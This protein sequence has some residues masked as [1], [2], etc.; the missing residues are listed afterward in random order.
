M[1]SSLYFATFDLSFS[2]IAGVVFKKSIRFELDIYVRVMS[3][4]TACVVP[5]EPQGKF[6]VY[7]PDRTIENLLA[8]FLNKAPSKHVIFRRS[9]SLMLMR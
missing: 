4:S 7:L 2:D 3:C 1:Y 5:Y 8:V 9:L 6:K